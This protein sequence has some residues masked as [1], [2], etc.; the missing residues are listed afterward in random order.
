M[1]IGQLLLTPR[2]KFSCAQMGPE[3][4]LSLHHY[5]PPTP[6]A[7]ISPY[8]FITVFKDPRM[9]QLHIGSVLPLGLLV[10]ESFH[11]ASWSSASNTF[12]PL[13]N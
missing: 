5:R 8:S 10:C 4:H 9:V 1:T 2:N 13:P 3:T 6:T 7:D 12:H 11:P